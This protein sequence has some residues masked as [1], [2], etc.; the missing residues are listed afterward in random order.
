MKDQWDFLEVEV[1]VIPRPPYDR[2]VRIAQSVAPPG[3]R[4]IRKPHVAFFDLYF[5][6][7]N[8]SLA[9]GGAYLRVRFDKRSLKRSG[10]Y[11]LFY[12][13]NP[14]AKP[15]D[16]F[17]SRREVRT[18]LSLDELLQYPS[19]KLPGSA[20]SLAREVLVRKCG[21]TN[22]KPVCVVSTFRRYFTMHSD[23]ESKTDCMNVSLEQ[24]TALRASDFDVEKLLRTGYIDAP[25]DAPTYDFELSEA[26]L[27]VDDSEEANNAFR[28]LV[29]AL[30]KEYGVVTWSKY[31][32]CLR[33]LKLH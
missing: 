9:R 19:G 3:F 11:K 13:D 28:A 20:G 5:D 18:D 24:S 25:I 17:L 29:D 32:E 14:I 1:K 12:K 7:A 33:W 26:E 30:D 31:R 4:M 27:T 16:R 8:Y 15:E 6:S 22:L 23:D 2:I 21:D 10:K